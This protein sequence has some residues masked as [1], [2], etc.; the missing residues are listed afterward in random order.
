[1][2]LSTEC[3]ISPNTLVASTCGSLAC[4]RPLFFRCDVTEGR[5]RAFWVLSLGSLILDIEGKTL[6][7]LTREWDLHFPQDSDNSSLRGPSLE[8]FNVLCVICYLPISQC[9]YND[10]RSGSSP[11]NKTNLEK[12]LV[13][14]GMGTAG[15]LPWTSL[16]DNLIL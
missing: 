14:P 15:C 13:G 16:L 1:M 11:Q 6:R 4:F 8:D 5:W 7:L 12:Y 9:S 10:K 3:A 2:F